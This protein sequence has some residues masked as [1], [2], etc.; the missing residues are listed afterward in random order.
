[1]LKHFKM[2]VKITDIVGEKTID[3]SYPIRG[4]KVAVV[5][6]FSGQCSVLVERAYESTAEN[7]RGKEAAKRGV[8]GQ[9]TKCIDRIGE[10]ATGFP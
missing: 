8:Y 4:T 5:S 7:R 1:M 6:V 2:Y 10:I 9:G 3:L